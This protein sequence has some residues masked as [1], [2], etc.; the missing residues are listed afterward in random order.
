ML[1]LCWRERLSAD[2][3]VCR[4]SGIAEKLQSGNL[5]G[6]SLSGCWHL[7]ACEFEGVTARE[8]ADVAS[9]VNDHFI[10]VS[11]S[12]PRQAELALQT[13]KQV[14]KDARTRGQVVADGVLAVKTPR[15]ERTERQFLT[16]AQVEELAANTE[17]PYGN[18]VQ[19]A[20]LTGLRQGE[21]F[22]LR[23][24]N[25]DLD[26]AAVTVTHTLYNGEFAPPKTRTS[27]RRVDLTVS[28][29]KLLKAQLLARVPN[30]DGLVFPSPL[31]KPFNDDNFRSRVFAPARAR[32]GLTGLR[33]HDLRHTYAALMI[34]AEAGPKYLQSQMGHTSIKVTLDDYGHL[35]PDANQPVLRALERLTLSDHPIE[36]PLKESSGNE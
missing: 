11:Q 17:E 28:A 7:L 1:V 25:L 23:D 30:E 33:F 19:L 13:L 34:R 2:Q 35:F 12:A 6:R 4:L 18:L 27:R 10:A 20:A 16:W 22:A 8:P 31:G 24:A 9:D 21:L 5:N 29:T 15:R 32:T 3:L 26:G 36:T 14:L